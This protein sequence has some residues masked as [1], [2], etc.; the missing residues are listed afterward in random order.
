MLRL[1]F[2]AYAACIA[3]AVSLAVIAVSGCDESGDTAVSSAP[4]TAATFDVQQ[5][6]GRYTGTWASPETNG[7]GP[8]TLTVAAEPRVRTMTMRAR[9]GGRYLGLPTTDPLFL[10]GSYNDRRAV[11]KGQNRIVGSYRVVIDAAGNA[12]G[13]GRGAF[14][15]LVPSVKFP[16]SFVNGDLALDVRLTL[17][18]GAEG[19]ILV[20][21]TRG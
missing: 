13:E 15:G 4:T 9:V 10:R 20:R 5:I 3:F 17:A 11:L 7:S 2:P 16:G 6:V 8:I 18:G 19:L 12:T 21:A 14:G 1:R